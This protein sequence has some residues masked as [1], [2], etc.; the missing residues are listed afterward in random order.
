VSP[1]TTGR[2]FDFF[3]NVANN[4]SCYVRVQCREAHDFIFVK[5]CDLYLCEANYGAQSLRTS[6]VS[7]ITTI[8]EISFQLSD[9]M[10]HITQKTWRT[11]YLQLWGYRRECQKFNQEKIVW[12]QTSITC[13]WF[14]KNELPGIWMSPT[15]IQT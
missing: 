6:L 3:L 15:Q 10:K 14:S 4:F 8:V 7:V 5:W 2:C 13:R 1:N 11:S 12:T 9:Y